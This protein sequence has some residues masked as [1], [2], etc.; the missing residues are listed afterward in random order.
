MYHAASEQPPHNTVLIAMGRCEKANREH[1]VQE[2]FAESRRHGMRLSACRGRG[3]TLRASVA[4]M[5]RH[6]HAVVCMHTVR[7]IRSSP[8]STMALRSHPARR[9]MARR[10][11]RTVPKPTDGHVRGG[12]CCPPG[13]KKPLPTARY[14]HRSHRA[15][16]ARRSSRQMSPAWRRQGE[17][18]ENESLG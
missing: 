15:Q 3:D 9:G 8:E 5:G 16:I 10:A 14:R 6:T 1:R 12:V 2:P 18:S 7:P 4:S 11:A 17:L 13:P